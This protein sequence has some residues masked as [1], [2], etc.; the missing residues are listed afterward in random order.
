ML[1]S[2]VC[3]SASVVVAFS[4][5]VLAQDALGHVA[6]NARRELVLKFATFDPLA[7]MPALPDRLMGGADIGLWIVQFDGAPNDSRRAHV[8]A[9]GGQILGYLPHNAYVVRMPAGAA[10]AVQR[11]EGVRFVGH[12]APAYR[13][14]RALFVRLGDAR[15]GK[16]NVVVGNKHVD[17]APLA[18]AIEA[19]GGRVADV[20]HGS[21]LL[22]AE[23]DGPQLAATARLDQVLWID[24][25][26]APEDDMDN[27]RIQGGANHVETV[28][29]YTGAG[30]RGHIYEGVQSTHYDFNTAPTNV[31]S[32]GNAQTHGHCTGGIVFGNGSSNAA[33][34]G[35]A[36]NATPFFTEYQT[37]VGTRNAI[38]NTVVN[39]HQCM[40]TTASWG[41][42]QTTAYTSVSADA[43]DIIFDHRIPWT[44]SQSN[45][46]NQ[47][48][49][50]QAWAKNIISVGAVQH[51]NNSNPA[52]DSWSAGNGS[53]G[54]AADGRIKP[55]LCAFYD[56]I[57]TSDRTGGDGYSTN[58][59]TPSFGGTSG[60]TP[61]VAGHNALAIQMYTDFVF[62]NT[63]TVPGG[64]RFQNRPLAQTLKTI[65]IASARQYAFTSG[66]TDNRREHQGWGFPN[67]QQLWDTRNRMFIV[68]ENEPLQQGQTDTYTIAVAAGEPELKVA[69]SFVD[70]AGNPAASLAA[71]NDLTL[72]VTSPGGLVYWGNNG[73][74]A[75]NYSTSGGSANTI[76]TVENVFVQNPQAGNWTVDVVATLVAQDAHLATGAVDATYALTAYGGTA[77]VA[78]VACA[79]Y[80]PDSNAAA[81]SC[82]V[83]PLGT[84]TNVS[85]P[86][87]FVS[88]N[89]GSSGG[90]VYFNLT[91]T[92]P[93]TIEAIDVNTTTSGPAISMEV[94]LT[95]PGGTH[96]GN[97]ANPN[98]WDSVGIASG[99]A[100]GLDVRSNLVLKQ[101]LTIRPGSYGMALRAIGFG[102]RYTNGTG[103]NQS[104]AN[105]DVAMQFGS[106]TNVAFS[107]SV[108]TPRVANIEFDY[109]VPSTATWRN[110]RYQT[111]VTAAQ[112]GGAGSISSVSLAPCGSGTHASE[113][114]RITMSH[115]PAGW[116][117]SSTFA[118]N[119]PAPVTVL[120]MTPHAFRYTQNQWGAV[121]LQTAFAYNG[122]SDL[123]IEVVS[124]GN[125]MFDDTGGSTGFRTG[126]MPRVYASG[127]TGAPPATGTVGSSA[128]LKM[129]VE[130][131]CANLQLY[132]TGCGGLQLTAS[133]SPVLG[134]SYT[135][136]ASGGAA[137]ST[138]LLY[139]GAIDF[140]Q[141]FDYHPFGYTNCYG[142]QDFSFVTSTTTDAAGNASVLTAVPN[143]PGLIGALSGAQFLQFNANVAGSYGFS[144]AARVVTGLAP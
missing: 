85:L 118:N 31:S 2:R 22:T 33:G 108:L 50:P 95:Q 136:A 112:L 128:A 113:S 77:N 125:K 65:M 60:A 36:P 3:A 80:V 116:S 127:W 96:V 84:A 44:Q 49:R 143:N 71:I 83:I 37:A 111:I 27:G 126:A 30:I 57:L 137:S 98:A 62:G 70:P 55:D 100:A 144:N 45:T 114:L 68:P 9:S 1:L 129:R 138:I 63:P 41:A 104:Y 64:T 120:N 109:A 140:S 15:V 93:I 115:V 6:D 7:R 66:S 61:M 106:A 28:G 40:F 131:G 119:L 107:G 10:S 88:N 38:I 135:V 16:Y 87:V 78:P 5:A 20:G 105:A 56:S 76:D 91:V 26:S 39:T 53:T 46:G 123:V 110:Q 121:G 54:P 32:G 29:G 47:N 59:W 51:F 48:S 134:G 34:R 82:N 132:G 94:Y 89:G 11:G 18:T 133:G 73:L 75:G 14:D 103:S 43:D 8:V 102:H 86:T 99:T 35:M 67:L 122:T 58:D 19:L 117:L 141:P 139:T 79:R 90:C 17:K 52:D 130:F 23:L 101:P 25:W 12:Y 13:L 74:S 4:V 24:A 69:M 97:E 142:W 81:G 21:I 92:N 42:A 72:R 124:T